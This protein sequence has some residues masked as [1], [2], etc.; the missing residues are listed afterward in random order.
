MDALWCMAER[1]LG[2]GDGWPEIAALNEGRVMK[3]GATFLAAANIRPG[4][5]LRVPKGDSQDVGEGAEYTY[6]VD[7]GDTLSEIAA[8]ELGSVEAWPRLYAANKQLLGPDP[9]LIYPGQVIVLPG[10]GGSTVPGTETGTRRRP[11]QDD[12]STGSPSE[13]VRGPRAE[14]GR[15]DEG[16]DGQDQ[17][18]TPVTPAMPE[19]EAPIEEPLTTG[20]LADPVSADVAEADENDGISALDALLASAVCLSAGAL[21]LLLH[22]RRRQWRARRIGR[23]IA[24]N[25]DEVVEVEE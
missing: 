19:Q 9:D 5:Q 8:D 21:G 11:E 2:D 24:F 14:S 18:R 25:P 6:Q 13:G 4:W 23:M 22:N 15:S 1:V 10:A 20:E 12:H 16:A 7:P 17:S 3:D